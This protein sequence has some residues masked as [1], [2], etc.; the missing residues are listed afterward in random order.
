MDSF[1]RTAD[2]IPVTDPASIYF[3]SYEEASDGLSEEDIINYLVYT[4]VEPEEFDNR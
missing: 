4:G 2:L 1:Y 3:S